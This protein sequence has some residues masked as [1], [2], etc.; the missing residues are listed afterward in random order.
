[1]GSVNV[2]ASGK[3]CLFWTEVPTELYYDLPDE[4]TIDAL[5]YCRYIPDQWWN[6]VSCAVHTRTGI[7]LEQCHV[8]YC[9][10][11]N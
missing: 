10:G 4:S 5:N 8:S 2:T 1:M 6:R 11:K 3:P 7:H 9:G